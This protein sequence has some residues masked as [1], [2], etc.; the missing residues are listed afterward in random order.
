MEV[1]KE[2][3]VVGLSSVFGIP[4]GRIFVSGEV[5]VVFVV[6]WSRRQPVTISMSDDARQPNFHREEDVVAQPKVGSVDQISSKKEWLA[7]YNHED[8]VA[9]KVAVNA[10]CD[11]L[12][13]Q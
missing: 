4:T 10:G 3:K 11:R 12:E 8:E 1:S 7:G 9:A 6:V 5:L 2:K 13:A